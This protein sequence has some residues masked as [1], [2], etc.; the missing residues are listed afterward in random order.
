M[1][2]QRQVGILLFDAVDVLDFSGPFEVFV[3][4][5]RLLREEHPFRVFT[6]AEHAAP[7]LTRGR[8]SVNPR[9][10]FQDCPPFDVLVV[11]GGA[12]VRR[13]EKNVVLL[14]WLQKVAGEAEIV[15]SI[16]TGALLLAQAGLLG[17]LAVT[18]HRGALEALRRAAPDALVRSEVRLVDAGH[19]VTSAGISAGIDA[20]LHVVAR[21]LGSEMA[22]RT[23]RAIEYAWRPITADCS[24]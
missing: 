16:S 24:A 3:I 23:A 2:A 22:E 5:D 20:A 1:S 13:E 10:T 9:Y 18:T 7:V 14:N 19:I 6:V 12:G 4:A 15:L 11:P 17:G 21:L 8:L